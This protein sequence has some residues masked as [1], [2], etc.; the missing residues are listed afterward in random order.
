M[1]KEQLSSSAVN[2]IGEVPP[3]EY[4]SAAQ[5][6]FFRLRLEDERRKLLENVQGTLVHMQGIV[7]ESDSNDRATA[8]EKNSRLSSGCR[9]A[10][11]NCRPGKCADAL[12]AYRKWHIRLVVRARGNPS[13]F[14]PFAWGPPASTWGARTQRH[15]LHACW[16]R[17]ACA[18][19]A[20][21]MTA[22]TSHDAENQQRNVIAAPTLG[23][24]SDAH[25]RKGS[26]A[27]GNRTDRR[28]AE[29]VPRGRESLVG[30][31]RHR[32]V[33]ARGG[34]GDPP[35]RPGLDHHGRRAHRDHVPCR[36]RRT[37]SS[38]R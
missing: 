28:S 23:A 11:G 25:Q 32:R 36:G 18:W 21:P 34:V 24:P 16:P 17:G 4:M 6:E 7:S 13:V 2:A 5:L 20:R 15:G 33:L 14:P 8:R 12:S 26:A 3:G 27:H 22:A 19:L 1:K 10:S 29:S 38:A 37:S 31:A 35:V 9:I 30:L